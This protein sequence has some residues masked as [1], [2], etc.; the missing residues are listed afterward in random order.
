MFVSRV[1]ERYLKEIL[2]EVNLDMLKEQINI[3]HRMKRYSEPLSHLMDKQVL[4]IKKLNLSSKLESNV[5]SKQEEEINMLEYL[6]DEYKTKESEY[7]K[8]IIELQDIIISLT[9]KT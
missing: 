5:Y 3:D 6:L 7:T 2:S 4:D 9:T 8:K 1:N